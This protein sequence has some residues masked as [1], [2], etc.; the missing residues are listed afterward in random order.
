MTD[1]PPGIL[2]HRE[3]P[4]SS[5]GTRPFSWASVSKT[6][7]V[8]QS[9]HVKLFD[10]PITVRDSRASSRGSQRDQSMRRTTIK[11]VEKD[12]S[13]SYSRT[14]AS[15]PKIGEQDK[16][17]L[18]T[19]TLK[20]TQPKIQGSLPNLLMLQVKNENSS[21]P[22]VAE[23]F[24]E[25][26]PASQKKRVSDQITLSFKFKPGHQAQ[27]PGIASALYSSREKIITVEDD[28]MHMDP[29]AQSSRGE[30]ATYDSLR[31]TNDNILVSNERRSVTPGAFSLR[32]IDSDRRKSNADKIYTLKGLDKLKGEQSYSQNL[33]K[34]ERR[35]SSRTIQSSSGIR[36][37]K[38]QNSNRDA[39]RTTQSI[40]SLKDLNGDFQKARRRPKSTAKSKV[41]IFDSKVSE[42]ER[43]R[44]AMFL[45]DDFVNELIFNKYYQVLD[46][47][48]K[49][50][51]INALKRKMDEHKVIREKY[52]EHVKQVDPN[53]FEQFNATR[54]EF[55]N[56]DGSPSNRNPTKLAK[57]PASEPRT[58]RPK[59]YS[60][61]SPRESPTA[62]ARTKVSVDSMGES[63]F[64]K[65][66]KVRDFDYYMNLE[67]AK[68]AS[69]EATK[70]KKRAK[71]QKGNQLWRQ[72][73]VEMERDRFARIRKS[74]KEKLIKCVQMKL[75]R[76]EVY[77]KPY[78]LG[79]MINFR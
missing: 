27:T 15:R 77:S 17:Q 48:E 29:Q 35:M 9:V 22:A 79:L 68:S 32:V 62:H 47:V 26:V 14:N 34:D 31:R 2:T 12:N 23:S 10:T 4:L 39:K 64:M 54:K 51:A 60:V 28:E 56:A 72:G 46:D 61:F 49:L 13:K 38:T 43:E 69:L 5:Q 8:V 37:V 3:K 70:K 65:P 30:R 59:A 45:K 16:Y 11:F 63:N 40:G 25:R 21:N 71:G 73:T 66:E 76:E 74:L 57:E 18:N 36:I 50:G 58:Q 67:L 52:N 53:F 55:W 19:T 42:Q 33:L 75:T 24:R 7:Q 1:L 44:L 6:M 20:M 41:G 78:F